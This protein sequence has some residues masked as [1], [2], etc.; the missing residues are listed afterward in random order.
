MVPA[1]T[2]RGQRRKNMKLFIQLIVVALAL[3]GRANAQ[4]SNWTTTGQ[5]QMRA[6]VYAELAD[7]TKQLL[8]SDFTGQRPLY[9]KGY[10]YKTLEVHM[11]YSV[12]DSHSGKDGFDM[13]TF[14]VYRREVGTDKDGREILL[15]T[16]RRIL[17][18]DQGHKSFRV[19]PEE[20]NL[21]ADDLGYDLR[22]K[23]G[24]NYTKIGLFFGLGPTLASNGTAVGAHSSFIYAL[25]YPWPNDGDV[26]R[27]QEYYRAANMWISTYQMMVDQLPQS[28][29]DSVE[30]ILNP[31]KPVQPPAPIDNNDLKPGGALPLVRADDGVV[32]TIPET[33][34][35]KDVDVNGNRQ[36][37]LQAVCFR[38]VEQ[39]FKF[40]NETTKKVYLVIKTQSDLSNLEFLSRVSDPSGKLLGWGMVLKPQDSVT[41]P[42]VYRGQV[43]ACRENANGT[44]NPVPTEWEGDIQ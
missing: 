13:E 27:Y 25:Q 16:P 42:S 35:V 5:V 30:L 18:D 44:Y 2:I 7:G 37:A 11:H 22:V 19:K 38:T 23:A 8:T 15:R 33:T 14:E 29:A 4:V 20:I 17:T 32:F 24:R 6:V 9:M 3:A 43:Q 12:A 21:G 26:K 1:P 28:V 40:R 41:L 34:K 36:P 10:P 39:G 31:P